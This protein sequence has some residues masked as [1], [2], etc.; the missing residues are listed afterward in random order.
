MKIVLQRVKQA[1]VAVDGKIVGEIGPGICLLIGVEKGDTEEDAQYLARKVIELRIFSDSEGKM[2]LSLID[3]RGEILAVSQFTLAASVEKGRRPGFDR[4]EEAEK[5]E[6]IFNY[7]IRLLR[8]R[9][10]SVETG[11]FGALMDVNLVNEGPVTFIL[12]SR[13]TVS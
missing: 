13:E 8:D 9:G 4:A 7:L 10:L 11:L 3:T 5:A 12:Q 6:N 2:N 1:S